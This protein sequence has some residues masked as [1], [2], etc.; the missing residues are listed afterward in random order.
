MS[1]LQVDASARTFA[2][3]ATKL[4]PGTAIPKPEIILPKIELEE[5]TPVTV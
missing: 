4:E 3:W 5:E 1:H 2:S